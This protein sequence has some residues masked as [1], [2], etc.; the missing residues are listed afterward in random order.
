MNK[1]KNIT[2]SF[3][4][5]SLIAVVLIIIGGV[6]AW[7]V[8]ESEN[9]M[10]T[11]KEVINIDDVSN[12]SINARNQIISVHA[13]AGNEARVVSSNVVSNSKLTVE[14]ISGVLN[15]ESRLPRNKTIVNI[16]FRTFT[17]PPRL[18]VYLPSAIYELVQISSTNGSIE[19]SDFDI[20][21]LQIESTNAGIEVADIVGNIN[22]RTTNGRIRAYRINGSDSTI[23]TTNASVEVVDIVGNIDAVTRNGRITISDVAGETV[24][25]ETTN[26][27]IELRNIKG[28]IKAQ[29]R[30][31]RIMLNNVTIEQNVRLQSTNGK[32]LVNL[33]N[34]PENATFDLRTTNGHRSIFGRENSTEQFGDGRY[35]VILRTTNGSV[36][37]E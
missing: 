1:I 32:V 30:N 6:G 8:G 7:L 17:D 9:E 26:N 14:V 12:V 29:T 10:I 4:L 36:M 2:K 11:L 22:V 34:E 28:D 21:D 5:L 16:S 3:R 33:G 31:G 15:I 37:V 23:R 25:I 27:Q 13:I 18:D 24:I 20:N 19:I 35:E